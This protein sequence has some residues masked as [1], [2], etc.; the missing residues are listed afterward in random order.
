MKRLVSYLIGNYRYYI[1]HIYRTIL[2][3]IM[4]VVFALWFVGLGMEI[5]RD[6]YPTHLL[7][8]EL[9]QDLELYNRLLYRINE[10][11]KHP[12]SPEENK[13]HYRDWEK[14]KDRIKRSPDAQFLNFIETG[15]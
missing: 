8:Q 4:G 1:H 3:I 15:E 9:A 12:T 7:C 13:E 5:S 2:L 14:E 10:E 11:L 6:L